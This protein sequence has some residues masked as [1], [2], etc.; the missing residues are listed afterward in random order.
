MMIVTIVLACSIGFQLAAA[1]MAFRLIN[2]TGKRIA[3]SLIAIA[4]LLM[5]IRR[6]IPFYYLL[7]GNLS[8]QPDILNEIIGLVLS[9]FILIGIII[10]TPY[11]SDVKL[12]EES[13][14][15]AEEKYRSL[16]NNAYDA[17]YLIEHQTQKIL[18]CNIKASEMIGYNLEELQGMTFFDLFLNNEKNILRTKL[19]EIDDMGSL[20][21]VSDIHHKKK[22]GSLVAIEMNASIV[23][24]KGKK[25]ILSVV[26]DITE[27]KRNEEEIR[28]FYQ[29]TDSSVE[30]I[31]FYNLDKKI[32]YINN[33]F[34]KMFG[35]T[36]EELVGKKIGM[37]YPEITNNKLQKAIQNTFDGGWVGEL[38]G[39]RKDDSLFP[40]SV[41]SSRILDNNGNIIA[42]MNSHRDITETKRAE[43][44][45]IT[46]TEQLR[47]LSD[48]LETV[49]EEERLK[50]A[51]E[52]HDGFGSSLTGLKMDLMVLKKNILNNNNTKVNSEVFDNIQSMSDLID[53]TIGLVRKLSTELRPG[54][55]DEL[56]LVEAI[57][58]YIKEFEKR[59]DIKS[60][61]T[62]FPKNIKTDT[63]LATT[64]FRI[65]QEILTNIMRHSKA[66]EVTV[67]LRKQKNL[68]SLLIHDNGIGIKKEE[69]TSKNSLGILGMQERAMI[70]GG[71]LEIEGIEGK[72]TIIKVE[73]PLY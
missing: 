69:V 22:D 28:L 27:R 4:L 3:W 68:I 72:G 50:L 59:T 6:I 43:K 54:I 13:V 67:F 49:R 66:T 11:L 38:I 73:I 70:F 53:S 20:Q 24:I 17:I 51:R 39:K 23:E 34:E 65:F 41:S 18:D 55:L 2:K 16:F 40:M 32:I 47:S 33:S 21:Y 1:V 10:I 8:F 25:F 37:I 29:A 44:K 14:K 31:C 26:R 7:S 42:R 62:V 61:F 57:R 46:Y 15:D 71:K 58:W 63:K 60:R 48:H 56:G 52:I 30:A 35:F 36:K 64:L 9:L 45:M 19:K 5:L 12:T